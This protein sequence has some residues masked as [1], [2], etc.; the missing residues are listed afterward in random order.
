[1][2]DIGYNG[3][4]GNQM[5]QLA[6]LYARA[7]SGGF[8]LR[9]PLENTSFRPLGPADAQTGNPMPVK[10]DLFDAFDLNTDCLRPLEQIRSHIKFLFNEP[11]FEYSADVLR[12]PDGTA[13]RGYFQSFRYFLECAADVRRLFTFKNAW[14]LEAE[15]YLRDV[16]R[17]DCELVSLHVRRTDYVGAANLHYALQN[18]Y[19]RVAADRVGAGRRFLIFSDDLDWCR[20]EFSDLE[21]QYV[22]TTS[23]YIDLQIMAMCDHHII[24]N[25]SYSW[26]GAWL[27]P[28]QSKTVI[29]PRQ[30]FAGQSAKSTKDL[31]PGDWMAI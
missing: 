27:N 23:P 30:W 3:R 4:L 19:Y 14:R 26:W 25:S 9:L 12:T 15:S 17:G 10:L 2:F 31:C 24:A 22:E 7:K 20:E 8:D 18:E 16:R 1:M 29:Y 21:A 11:G 13:F 6:A 28:T 5:F